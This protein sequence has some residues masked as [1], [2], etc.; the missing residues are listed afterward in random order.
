MSKNA[1]PLTI[2]AKPVGAGAAFQPSIPTGERRS[3]GLFLVLVVVGLGALDDYVIG[4]LFA[5][6][7][8]PA[9]GVIT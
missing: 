2:S 8:L 7:P 5:D 6:R 3:A 9:V 4:A 1:L